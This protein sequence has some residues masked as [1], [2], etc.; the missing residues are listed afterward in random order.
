MITGTGDRAF[1]AGGDIHEQRELD[2]AEPPEATAEHR[3]VA[4]RERF[5]IGTCAKPTVGMIN[6]LAYGGAAALAASLDLRVGCEH[7]RFRFLA[8]T[9]GRINGTWTLPNQVG[10]PKAK[11]LLFTGRE[12]NAP[13][14]EAIG[15]LNRLVPCA[16]LRSATLELAS[17]IAANDRAAV[18]GVK[19]LIMGQPGVSLEDQW[20]NEVDYTTSVHP[21]RTANESFARFFDRDANSPE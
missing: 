11:E 16:E 19:A 14:A 13:E 15:L 10:W 6:G 1:S 2:E 4:A 20:T 12:V 17:S 8:V 18:Q 9:Y 5:A 7:A 21:P 3:A